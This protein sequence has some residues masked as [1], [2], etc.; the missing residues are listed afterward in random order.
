MRAASATSSSPS[1]PS[2]APGR[3]PRTLPTTARRS[4]NSRWTPDALR[5]PLCPRRRAEPRAQSARRRRSRLARAPYPA[6]PP[7][8]IAEGNAPAVCPKGDRVAFL[9]GD[10]IWWAP[11]D[12]KGLRRARIPS[13]AASPAAPIWSPDGAR[14]AFTSSRGDHALIGVYDVAADIAPL[15]RPE[16]RLRSRPRMVARQPQRRL[17]P[18]SLPAVCA[19]FANRGAAG[20]PWSIR[21]AAAETGAGREVWRAREGPGSVFREVSP[22]QSVAVGR[23]RP[24]RLPVGGATAGRTS[25]R[26]PRRAATRTLLTPGEFEVEDVASHADQRA[27]S[28]TPPTR[29]ISTGGISG[30]SRP[31]AARRR[32]SLP[33]RASNAVRRPPA[34]ADRVPAAPTR[35]IR[36]APRSA[37]AARSAIS[38]R[39]DPRRLPRAAAWSRRSR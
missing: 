14:I 17:H 25:T 32:R 8:K 18:R 35:S 39:R 11:L 27:R 20:E 9:R 1:R 34:N 36:C 38:T 29:A 2:I 28:S 21:V 12:G 16:H 19:P 4:R 24:H 26:S 22:P 31:P 7:R 10:Q 33:D 15:S 37:S 6:A 13:R 23:R 3:S 30:R 5:R